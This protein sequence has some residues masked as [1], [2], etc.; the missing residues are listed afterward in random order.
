[1]LERTAP[2]EA[3]AATSPPTR[4]RVVFFTLVGLSMVGLAWLL[5]AALSAGGLGPADF[6]LVV[7]FVV[8]LPWS[9]IGFWN[10]TVGLVIMRFAHDPVAAVTP[11]AARITGDEP[12]RA[13]TAILACIRNEPPE[14]VI[15][16]LVP[17]LEG[18]SAHGMAH[19]FHVYVLSDT[20]DLALAAMERR[21][22]TEFANAWSGRIEITYRRRE[23]NIAFK[24]GNIRDFCDRWGKH[25]DFALV[26]DADSLMTADCV[27]RMVRIMQADAR[28]GILQSLVTGM[29][30]TSAFAR[31]FQFGMRL[32]M[33]SYTIG[34]AWWQ[35][36]CGPY[37]GHNALVR[38]EPF[39]THCHLPIL[40]DTALIPGHVLSHDQVEAV[41]MRR[42]GYEVR[43]LPEEGGS[44]EQNPSDA[45]RVHPARPALVPG[46]HA[47]LALPDDARSEAG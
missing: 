19:A 26:L 41:L 38:L 8:T 47:V 40:G 13:S 5:A 4:R 43:V 1:M 11:A 30:S 36:D 37:W 25:H 31:I 28:L 10:A 9:V 27:L 45:H 12:I 16:H 14:H 46:Q 18:I 44:F 29:P 24:A 34:S 15:S 7:L 22:V 6:L 33:R 23:D 3:L 2:D 32:G 39:M 17:L 20:T 21:H 42:A 35:A